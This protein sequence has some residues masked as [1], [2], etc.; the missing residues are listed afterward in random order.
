M[1]GYLRFG[2]N[3]QVLDGNVISSAVIGT[4]SVSAGVAIV[5]FSLYLPVQGNAVPPGI[6]LLKMTC[7]ITGQAV[8]VS[9]IDSA[10]IMIYEPA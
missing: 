9:G 7:A 5:P 10:W 1:A 3:S 2:G 8:A 4:L 6:Q